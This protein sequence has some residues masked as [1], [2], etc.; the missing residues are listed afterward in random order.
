MG[1]I[2]TQC[3]SYIYIYTIYIYIYILYKIGSPW[4]HASTAT[5][6]YKYRGHESSDDTTEQPFSRVCL[7]KT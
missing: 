4:S 1:N 6:G 5:G 2:Y 3:V 7:L